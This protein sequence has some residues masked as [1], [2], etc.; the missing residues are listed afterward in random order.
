MDF[1]YTELLNTKMTEVR[2][3]PEVIALYKLFDALSVPIDFGATT[4]K[5]GTKLYRIRMYNEDTDYGEDAQWSPPPHKPENRLNTEGQEALYLGSTEL[6]CQLETHIKL[7]E[8]Y[9][10][11]E[12]ECI[13]DIKLGGFLMGDLFT[14][15][16][17]A[18]AAGT[19][20]SGLYKLGCVLNSVLIAPVLNDRNKLLF[21]KLR[22]HYGA[23]KLDDLDIDDDSVEFPCKIA[24]CTKS[25]TKYNLTNEIS[26][27]L[28][29][30]TPEGI[31]YSSCYIPLESPGIPCSDYNVVLYEPG[32]SKVKFKGYEIKT[33]SNTITGEAILTLGMGCKQ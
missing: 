5:K 11:G 10:L 2:T 1:K 33:C 20:I 7:G 22:E 28:V 31:R 16:G 29:K 25:D 15:L 3:I 19:D 30:T 12:Y 26:S 27:I 23:L 18:F 4:L 32:I 6:V 17:S 21:Q 24:L 13:E 9:V 8:Q 14:K